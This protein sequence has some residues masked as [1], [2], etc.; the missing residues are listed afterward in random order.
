[1]PCRRGLRIL[2]VLGQ[3]DQRRLE[4]L[5]VKLTRMV[6]VE[7]VEERLHVLTLLLAVG[8]LGAFL[9]GLEQLAQAHAKVKAVDGIVLVAIPRGRERPGL[10]AAAHDHATH[11]RGEGLGDAG[12]VRLP[13]GGQSQLRLR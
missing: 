4:L 10:V 9:G 3:P 1:M 11:A 8:L 12:R 7:A 6:E 2:R 13:L 5:E